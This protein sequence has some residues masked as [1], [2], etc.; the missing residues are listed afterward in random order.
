MNT[1]LLYRAGRPL[2]FC[3]A[4][5]R[6]HDVVLASLKN[7]HALGLSGLLASH[8]PDD[9]VDV[10][11][12]RFPN[13]V[14]LAAGLDKN[15][16]YIEALAALGFGFLEIG[17]VTPR[18]QPGNPKPRMFRLVSRQAL[19]NRLGFNN[20]GLD[21]VLQ[22]LE[23]TRFDGVLGVNIG[24][25]KDT[26]NRDAVKDY[27]TGLEAVF[28]HASYITVNISS[29]NTEGLRD[30]Q[31]ADPLTDLLAALVEKRNALARESDRQVPLA[32]KI[33]PDLTPAELQSVAQVINQSGVEAVIATNTTLDRQAVAG[34]P[35]GE[36][37]GGLSGAPLFERAT[38]VLRSMRAALRPELSL[39][40][41]GGIVNGANAVS[42]L[43]AGADLVQIYT[44]L[45]YRGPELVG[46]IGRAIHAAELGR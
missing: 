38:E 16:D 17:T 34:L 31:Q 13:R 11:G 4:P 30:L 43:Q 46:E 14:G 3:M 44:G 39:I 21:H 35:H 28:P 37:A 5:E 45:I 20:K 9:P 10:M 22:R 7:A 23:A 29:P 1:G 42:K 27:L 40:G 41:V 25:N 8:P 33:A 36:E 12:I 26:P 6:A 19:I 15:G 24:K 32:L 2:I 18:P